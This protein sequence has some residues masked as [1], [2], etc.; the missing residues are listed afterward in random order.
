MVRHRARSP[1]WVMTAP[2]GYKAP[3]GR[4]SSLSK[5]R[6]LGRG[7]TSSQYRTRA[8]ASFEYVGDV[9]HDLAHAFG[10]VGT[11]A[12]QGSAPNARGSR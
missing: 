5:G 3:V 7:S 6:G 11:R 2:M 9:R 12:E 10:I 4:S 8:T 1:L